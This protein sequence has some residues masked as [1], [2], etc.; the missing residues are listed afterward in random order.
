MVILRGCGGSG[1]SKRDKGGARP[2]FYEMTAESQIEKSGQKCEI[3][4]K[5]PMRFYESTVIL[6]PLSPPFEV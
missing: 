5:K 3:V 2:K 1:V 6:Q 4:T